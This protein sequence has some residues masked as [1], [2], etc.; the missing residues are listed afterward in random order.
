MEKKNTLR[1]LFESHFSNYIIQLLLRDTI[2]N[3][4]SFQHCKILFTYIIHLT[5]IHPNCQF[6]GEKALLPIKKKFSDFEFLWIKKNTLRYLFES[7][8]SR[9]GKCR[10]SGSERRLRRAFYFSFS[11]CITIFYP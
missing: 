1:Y 10:K 9:F 7:H 2:L 4:E 5:T 6:E 8:F 3:K 11:I